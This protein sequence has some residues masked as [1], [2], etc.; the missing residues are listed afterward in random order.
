VKAVIGG[1]SFAGKEACFQAGT[2]SLNAGTTT[3]TVSNGWF[4]VRACDGVSAT[5]VIITNLGANSAG[6]YV[7]R[8]RLKNL[9]IQNTYLL[10]GPVNG[11]SALWLDGITWDVGTL[12]NNTPPVPYAIGSFFNGHI[13]M[14][15]TE[16]YNTFGPINQGG[17][18]W[19]NV[20]VHDYNEDFAQ[21]VRFIINSKAHGLVV[22]CSTHSDVNQVSTTV[23][24]NG[25]IVY[26]L[27]SYGSSPGSPTYGATLFSSGTAPNA[28]ILHDAAY[29]DVTS[30]NTA[31][32]QAGWQFGAVG[33][34]DNVYVAN[35]NMT[36][37]LAFFNAMTAQDWTILDSTCPV[38]AIGSYPGVTYYG[39]PT[40]D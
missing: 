24:G 34:H 30:N 25:H 17:V 19:R 8:L 21:A 33:T 29:V 40:C 20:D 16:I 28:G 22:C 3:T 36:T 4:T 12:N 26:G 39:S 15:D 5:S 7:T 11:G 32:G 9:K 38:A 10:N 23:G 18:T 2:Y 6:P 31:G 27:E 37:N 1:A 14:S 35:L 13:F